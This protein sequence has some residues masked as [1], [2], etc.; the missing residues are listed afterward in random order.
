MFKHPIVNLYFFLSVSI[1]L[2]FSN[3]ISSLI[4]FSALLAFIFVIN[5]QFALKA[6]NKFLATIF[7]LPF[8]LIFYV[9]ISLFFTQMTFFESMRNAFFAFSKLSIIMLLM[10]IYMEMS[11]AEKLIISF[12]SLWLNTALKWKWVDDLFLFL[13]LVLRLYPTFRSNWTINRASLKAIGIKFN[14]SYFGKLFDI[15]REL[16]AMLA[17][18][19]NRSNDIALAMRL[20]GY[21][22]QYPR[23]VINPIYFSFFNLVQIA[24]ITFLLSCLIEFI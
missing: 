1:A 16:P 21:G 6:I 18:Q 20:R 13:S 24:L 14:K 2:V 9:A 22:L 23:T 3:S 4:L 17:Y 15:S 5:N 8:M 19:L 11:S 12:R 10:N 7:F